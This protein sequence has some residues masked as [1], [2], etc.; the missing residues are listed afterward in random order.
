MDDQSS[1]QGNN[2]ISRGFCPRLMML[3][4]FEIPLDSRYSKLQQYLAL[5]SVTSMHSSAMLSS[6]R[7]SDV[8][9]SHFGYERSGRGKEEG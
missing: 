6:R 2:I 8:T 4:L 1:P 5:V 3:D 9:D 7:R